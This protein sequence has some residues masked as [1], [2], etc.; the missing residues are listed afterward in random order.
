MIVISSG[1]VQVILTCN[2]YNLISLDEPGSISKWRT[3]ISMYATLLVYVVQTDEFETIVIVDLTVE[4]ASRLTVLVG[5]VHTL[6]I[7]DGFGNMIRGIVIVEDT[8]GSTILVGGVDTFSLIDEFGIML[9][10]IL[11]VEKNWGSTL[12]VDE[13]HTV[14]IIDGL[15]T[16]IVAILA[17]EE[18]GGSLVDET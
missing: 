7:I 3:L 18:I 9:V 6:S 13:G 8:S 4:E 10:A 17:A 15:G 1:I 2:S 12:L 5:G 14:T 11:L 16:M